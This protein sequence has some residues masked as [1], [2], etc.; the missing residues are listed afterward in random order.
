MELATEPPLTV[1]DKAMVFR[2]GRSY[3]PVGSNAPESPA[4][5][6]P[7]MKEWKES[8][9]K[10]FSERTLMLFPPVTRK[11]PLESL[12]LKMEEPANS[13]I[14]LPW[15]LELYLINELRRAKKDRST[16]DWLNQYADLLEPLKCWS[17]EDFTQVYSNPDYH[18]LIARVAHMGPQSQDAKLPVLKSMLSSRW[19]VQVMFET[20][21]PRQDWMLCTIP[22]A[23][24]ARPEGLAAEILNTCMICLVEGNAPYVI[25][26]LAPPSV[27]RDLEFTVPNLGTNDDGVFAQLKKHQLEFEADGVTL[28]WRIMGVRRANAPNKYRGMFLLEKPNSYW[29]WSYDWRHPIGSVPPPELRPCLASSK[30]ICL[31]SVL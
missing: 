6:D 21:P 25:W 17:I 23:D 5:P 8:N 22:S 10:K 7:V 4:R 19:N 14:M 2:D 28:G 13:K 15:P 3:I 9:Y 24:G 20:I 1:L 31:C 30:A 29:P 16:S 12:L 27:I 26:H 11:T 18:F